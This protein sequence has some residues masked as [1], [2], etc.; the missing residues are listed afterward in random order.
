MLLVE[1]NTL[2]RRSILAG[3]ARRGLVVI[4]QSAVN[5]AANRAGI[6]AFFQTAMVTAMRGGRTV[7]QSI[8]VIHTGLIPQ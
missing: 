5:R 8:M 1:E 7:S 2:V 3:K 4:I 6:T